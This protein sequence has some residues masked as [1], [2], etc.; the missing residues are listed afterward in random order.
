M[1]SYNHEQAKGHT[2][3]N[4][5]T[6]VMKEKNISLQEASDFVGSTFKSLMEQYGADKPSLRTF[7]T[8]IDRSVKQYIEAMEHWVIGSLIWS[9]ETQRYFGPEHEEVRRTLVVHLKQ[10]ELPDTQEI[11][12]I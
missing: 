2:G 3:S 6:V 8:D 9:F 7:G 5:L 1:Y 10:V 11:K 12:D 4:F